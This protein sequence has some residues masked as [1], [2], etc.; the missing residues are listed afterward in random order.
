MNLIEDQSDSNL[1]TKFIFCE[2]RTDCGEHGEGLALASSQLVAVPVKCEIER[3]AENIA[4]ALHVELPTR[5]F[6]L[7]FASALTEMEISQ[8]QNNALHS[9]KLG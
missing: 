5:R 1:T 4:A 8:N 2:V 7:E 6:V 9:E 3:G